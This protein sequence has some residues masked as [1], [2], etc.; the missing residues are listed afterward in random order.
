MLD[1]L[2]AGA[3]NISSFPY[4]EHHDK[5]LVAGP[6]AYH[7]A[8]GVVRQAAGDDTYFLSSTG[9]S[10]HNAGIMD[11]IRTGSD[12]GEG[13]P[14]YPDSYFYPATYVVNDASFG[15]G[16][17]RALLNQASAY[18]THRKLYINDSG[19]VLTVD[20]P[21][22]LGDA[23]IHATIHAMSGG[24][25]M[26]GDDVDYI[27]EERLGLIKKTLPRSTDV[28]FPVDL[29]ESVAPDYPKVF[30]RKVT[31]P[32]GSFDVV[33][34]YNFGEE[35]LRVPVALSRLGLKSGAD[36]LVWEFWNEQYLGRARETL[37]A[38]VPPGRVRV[39]RLAENLGVPVLLGT[40]MHV[41]MGEAEVDRCTWDEGQR[42]LSGRAVRPSGESGNVFLYVPPSMQVAEAEGLWI[43]KDAGEKALIVRASLRFEAGEASWQVCF[44]NRR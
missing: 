18:Y 10:V 14:L 31:K 3:G 19:N 43:A 28:A 13:R 38:K 39:Y 15:T 17:L 34:V 12:F 11:A 37:F 6:E 30:H 4:A 20:K 9:P 22:P 42:I 25:S 21:L 32:W 33:A 26:L 8:L 7:R 2:H 16:P 44:E 27:D 40:D 5:R 29:F 23:Q 1:F 41:L 24:P 36:Y 35:L